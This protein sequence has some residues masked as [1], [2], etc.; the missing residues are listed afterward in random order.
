VKYKTTFRYTFL[1]VLF[2][3]LFPVISITWNFYHLHLVVSWESFIKIQMNNPMQW[4]ID[5]A[6]LF[7][8]LFASLTGMRQA[9]VETLNQDLENH[10]KEKNSLVEQLELTRS[11]L[12]REVNH[13]IL[14]LE[15]VAHVA[16]EAAGIRDL[17]KLLAQATQ[18]I[19]EYFDFYHVSIFLLDTDGEHVVLRASAGG[20]GQ[21]MLKSGRRL[22]IGQMGLV[23]HV[24]ETGQPRIALDLDNDRTYVNDPDHPD[25]RSE[26]ALP[27]K[28]RKRLMGV[29]DVRSTEAGAFSSEDLETLQILA[30]QIAL[31]IDNAHL[32]E[33][34][35]QSLQE[36]E[37]LYAQQMQRAWR[38][39]Y[40]NQRLG[41]QYRQF[42]LTPISSEDLPESGEAEEGHI[43]RIPL[44]LRHQTIGYIQ[45]RRE[46]DQGPWSQRETQSI[47]KI[48]N[49]IALSLENARL[50]A[51]A[52]G[53][54][55]REQKI[56]AITNQIRNSIDLETVLQN[57]VRELGKALGNS[58]TFIQV[59]LETA[60]GQEEITS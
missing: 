37:F 57:T 23:G 50:F 41:Y 21:Q 11:G 3:L 15:A 25:T 38:D 40:K 16:R 1:G 54:V 60:D 35:K 45:L 27:L 22:R 29:L 26:M 2:G 51:E 9:E 10:L 18:L 12:A 33:E 24:A 31:S 7:L 46:P 49:Q 34:S 4:L 20:G 39:Q 13:R 56:N 19:S 28:I 48:S 8:G 17:D 44:K 36:L 59:G 42:K 14:A 58:K 5:T 52:R 55:Q 53:V 43:H 6:P 32:L 30:D 47:E